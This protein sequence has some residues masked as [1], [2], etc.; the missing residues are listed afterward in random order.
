MCKKLK[1]PLLSL[2]LFSWICITI[3]LI[4]PQTTLAKAL[5]SP[6]FRDNC[7]INPNLPLTRPN[8]Q[9]EATPISVG[10]Y[11]LDLSEI[12]SGEQTVKVD[13][14]LKLT[15]SDYRLKDDN[16]ILELA[17]IWYPQVYFL[18]RSD[19]LYLIFS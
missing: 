17:N 19:R 16:C 18:N 15:W 10:I 12:K 4:Q 2:L 3:C 13:F 11:I 14:L 5:I 9:G 8:Y 1:P 7:S 6:D